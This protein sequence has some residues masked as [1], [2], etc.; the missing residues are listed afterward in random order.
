[1]A[2]TIIDV[3]KLAKTSKSTVSRYLNGKPV[4]KETE[5]ALKKAIKELNYHPNM[6]ARRLV[7]NRT[8]VIGIVVDDISNSFYS[9]IL[10]GI[11]E[12]SNK[13]GFDCV[14]YSWMSNHKGERDFINLLYEEQVDGL[15]FL[16]FSKREKEV[17]E[18][19]KNTA[20]AVVLIGDDAGIQDVSSIDVDNF[21]GVGDVVRYLHRIGHRQLAYITG[22][23]SAGAT[24]ERTN[25]FEKTIRELGLAFNP[26][27]MVSSDWSNQGGYQAMKQLLEVGGFTAVV[28]SNDQ[29]ALGA[30]GAAHEQ[31]YSIPKDFSIVGFDDIEIS[32]WIYPSLT[33]VR[34]PFVDIGIK[35]AE[36]LF[37]KIKGTKKQANSRILLKP[38]LVI[39]NS[40]LNL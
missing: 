30:I 31:G 35:A 23:E 28:A 6:N 1:M 8:Q 25:G 11:T 10:K 21:S 7:L 32:K 38:N 3:A 33:T 20:F 14:F 34:Q 37:E 12:V 4:K 15:I 16:N 39:R 36:V 26:E 5:E 13:N 2:P 17:V 22:P 19:M 24:Q 40:C 9:G 29:T 27:L 18:E